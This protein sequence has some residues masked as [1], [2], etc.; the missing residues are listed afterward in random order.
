MFLRIPRNL[1]AQRKFTNYHNRI[2]TLSDINKRSSPTNN[3]HFLLKWCRFT[4]NIR[5]RLKLY[6]A[7]HLIN[8]QSNYNLVSIYLSP[9]LEEFFFFFLIIISYSTLNVSINFCTY[10][11]FS[12]RCCCCRFR[13][14][15][16]EKKSFKLSTS[17]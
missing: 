9:S 3:H 17:N 15:Q 13:K 6:T 11:F 12:F 8:Y 5:Y 10:F 4:G 1:C 2:I 14:V 16:C 7:H